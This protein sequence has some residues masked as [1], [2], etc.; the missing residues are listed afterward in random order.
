MHA[1]PSIENGVV[2]LGGCDE[3]FRG[4]RLAD[5]KEVLHFPAGGYTGRRLLWSARRAYY[6]TF[7]NDVV[8]ADLAQKRIVWHYENPR[9]CIPVLLL[10]GACWTT[11]SCWAAATSWSTA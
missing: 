8:A 10:G 3:V 7:S 2:Y 6:G 9:A 4:V 1:T 11:G 5:G